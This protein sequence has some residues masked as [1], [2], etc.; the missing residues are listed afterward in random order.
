[1]NAPTKLLLGLV[2]IIVSAIFLA[3]FP[4]HLFLLAPLLGA[5]VF[6]GYTFFT[7]FDEVAAYWNQRNFVK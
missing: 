1:M 4:Q 6:V 3:I 2:V 5:V 7:R